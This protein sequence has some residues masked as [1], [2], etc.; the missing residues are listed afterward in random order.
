MTFTTVGYQRNKEP[1]LRQDSERKLKDRQDLYRLWGRRGFLNRKNSACKK[2]A[3]KLNAAFMVTPDNQ[4]S[5]RLTERGRGSISGA[6]RCKG[7]EG[8]K[9]NEDRR[10]LGMCLRGEALA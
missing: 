4:P 5:K 1:V 10:M 9:D 6:G 8:N 3:W 7:T 2:K